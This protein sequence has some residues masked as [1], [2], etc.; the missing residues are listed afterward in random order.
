MYGAQPIQPPPWQAPPKKRRAG[1]GDP[2]PLAR[3][4]AAWAIDF[5]VIVTV[6]LLV[7]W[8][9]YER[10]V[11]YLQT[12]VVWHTGFSVYHLIRSGGSV[13]GAAGSSVS[14]AWDHT[15]LIIA[16]GILLTVLAQFLY[17]F[18]ALAWKGRTAG[19]AALGL[20]VW[21]HGVPRLGKRRA[22]LR[23]AATTAAETLVYGLALILLVSWNLALA[24]V[25]WLLSVVAFTS[26]LLPMITAHPR[27]TVVDRIGG[28]IVVR[29]F[30]FPKIAAAIPRRPE[31]GS[32]PQQLPPMRAPQQLPPVQLP[33]IEAPR[34]IIHPWTTQSPAAAVPPPAYPPQA[35]PAP[36]DEQ[37]NI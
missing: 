37:K 4:A 29:S 23:A 7:A 27:R 20:Q 9:T 36:T 12:T 17:Q 2:A 28:T 10:I 35:A 13:T 24:V 30:V 11:G 16:E 34:Q 5:G 14:Q 15:L 8:M 6:G 26:N 31:A 19:K 32:V 3:R 1:H 18:A 21:G 33:Q 25:C 22:A